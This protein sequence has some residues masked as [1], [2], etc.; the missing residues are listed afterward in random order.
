LNWPF[1]A[2]LAVL[3]IAVI[4]GAFYIIIRYVDVQQLF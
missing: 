1:A 3:V 4:L 2:A